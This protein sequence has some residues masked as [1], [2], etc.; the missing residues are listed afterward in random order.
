MEAAQERQDLVADQAALRVGVGRVD[1]EVEPGRAAVR[2]RLLPPERQK[3][4]D[5]PVVGAGDDAGRRAARDEPVEDRL[6]LVR[7]GVTGRPQ[8][9]A[10][11]GT[12]LLA[13]RGLGEP[14]AGALHDLGA[15]RLD[16]EASVLGGIGAAQLVIH[17]QRRDPIAERAEH[18]PEAGRVGAPGDETRDLAAGRDQLVPAD[19]ALD[20]IAQLVHPSIVPLRRR[21]CDT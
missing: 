14:S 16:A 10:S 9:V 3:R 6:D 2:L 8:A 21:D 12:P 13:Q 18:V 7:G 11:D 4:V 17:V 19:E 1:P 15:E 20:A 5:D